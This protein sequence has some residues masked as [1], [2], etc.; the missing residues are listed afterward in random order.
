MAGVASS[1]RGR[2]ETLHDKLD[3]VMSLLEAIE[4]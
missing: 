2:Q 4:E 1:S 3:K